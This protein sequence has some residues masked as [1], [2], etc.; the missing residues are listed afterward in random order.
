[1]LPRHQGCFFT[2]VPTYRNLD[3]IQQNTTDSAQH[4]GC[5]NRHSF[6]SSLVLVLT[7]SLTNH[8]DQLAQRFVINGNAQT[9]I[10]IRHPHFTVV[11]HDRVIG[12]YRY[13]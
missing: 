11:D 10:I 8:F 7:Y 13:R 9:G 5:Q 2:T 4:Q 12:C 3:S 1:M 6:K